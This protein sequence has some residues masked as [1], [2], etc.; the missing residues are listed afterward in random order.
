MYFAQIHLESIQNCRIKHVI[1]QCWI[2]ECRFLRLL[3]LQAEKLGNIQK[4][5]L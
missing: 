5:S 3:T 1:V 2:V 4:S